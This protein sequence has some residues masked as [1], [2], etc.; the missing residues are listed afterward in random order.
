[1][2]FLTLLKQQYP[3]TMRVLVG[4]STRAKG[5]KD[6]PKKSKGVL[7]EK[8][9]RALIEAW[10]NDANYLSQGLQNPSQTPPNYPVDTFAGGLHPK[11]S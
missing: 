1:M 5:Q 9:L 2:D 8:E 11:L 7:S 3:N 4:E 6:A 10:S